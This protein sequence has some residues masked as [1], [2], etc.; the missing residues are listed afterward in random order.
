MEYQEA[1]AKAEKSYQ[2][3]DFQTSLKYYKEALGAVPDDHGRPYGIISLYIGKARALLGLDNPQAALETLED[4]ARYDHRGLFMG[5]PEYFETL[6]ECQKRLGHDTRNAQNQLNELEMDWRE[7]LTQ[8]WDLLNRR[9]YKESLIYFE[10]S[11]NSNP[12]EW[13][14]VTDMREAY[15]GIGEAYLKLGRR[16]EAQ[17]WLEKIPTE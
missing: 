13:Y 1:E 7:A 3:G 12:G 6:M 11:L 2:Q 4:L 16:D 10:R 15:K 14:S 17:F 8:A 5:Y 9:K